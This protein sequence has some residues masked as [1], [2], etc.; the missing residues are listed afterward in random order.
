MH[1]LAKSNIESTFRHAAAAAAAQQEVFALCASIDG[2]GSDLLAKGIYCT[3]FSGCTRLNSQLLGQ[4]SESTAAR[5]V[6]CNTMKLQQICNI[7]QYFHK[8]FSTTKNAIF[9]SCRQ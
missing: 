6:A 8:P 2:F 4:Q 1:L 7:W 9:K 3:Y 5:T